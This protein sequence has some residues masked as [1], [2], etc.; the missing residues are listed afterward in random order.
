VGSAN[1]VEPQQPTRVVIDGRDSEV[2]G[3]VVVIIV[4]KRHIKFSIHI[5]VLLVIGLLDSRCCS[6][7]LGALLFFVNDALEGRGG[8]GGEGVSRK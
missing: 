3:G 7:V 2:V 4:S 6:K 8:G 5:T 1:P